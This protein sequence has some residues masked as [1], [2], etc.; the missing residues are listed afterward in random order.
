MRVRERE[1]VGGREGEEKT[2]QWVK[3]SRVIELSITKGVN[4]RVFR[5]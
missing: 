5:T 3:N 4:K 1:G 2:K